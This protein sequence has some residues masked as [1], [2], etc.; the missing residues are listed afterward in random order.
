MHREVI[1]RERCKPPT[2]TNKKPNLREV[3]PWARTTCQAIRI[4]I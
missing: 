3:P 4:V 2:N 1:Y